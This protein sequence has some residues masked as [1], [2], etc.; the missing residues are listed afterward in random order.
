MWVGQGPIFF[1]RTTGD[2]RVFGSGCDFDM[3]LRDYESEL[4][5]SNGHWCLWLTDDH[6]RPRVIVRLKG[7]L[8]I[9]TS[10]AS[11]LVT[12]LPCCLFSGKRRH[13]EWMASKLT[14]CSTLTSICNLVMIRLRSHSCY[15]KR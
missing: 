7:S 4:A 11:K 9:N 14:E 12:H 3:E 5:A 2:I 13:L 8:A 10:S 6:S 1:N 15:R